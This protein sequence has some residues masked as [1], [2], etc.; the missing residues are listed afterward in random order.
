[1]VEKSNLEA[2]TISVT[3]SSLLAEL[4]GERFPHFTE[5]SFPRLFELQ[6]SIRPETTAIVCENQQLTFSELN[7]RANQLARYLQAIGIKPESIVGICVD[8]WFNGFL[9]QT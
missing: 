4:H 8:R 5:T 6:V 3:G 9:R 1:M 2:H 7:A